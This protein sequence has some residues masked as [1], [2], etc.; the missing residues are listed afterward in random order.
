VIVEVHG[1]EL[2]GRHGADEDERREPQSFLFD[3]T[4]DIEE[5]REDSLDATVDYRRVRDVIRKVSDAQSY[6]LLEKLAAAAADA[7]SAELPV[8]SVRVRVRKPGVRWAEWAAATVER[9]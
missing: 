9:P 7:I 2:H 5:P 8:R 3:V 6:T 1:L 4:I